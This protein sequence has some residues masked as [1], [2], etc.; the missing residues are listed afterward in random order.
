MRS[1]LR[2]NNM[3]GQGSARRT[4]VVY[5]LGGMGKTQLAV[6]YATWHQH[7]YSA[8]FW[9]NARDETT[10]KQ[11]FATVA[12][13]ILRE[14]PSVVYVAN[15]IQSRDLDESV[16]AVKRWLDQ[17][18]NNHWLIVYNNYNNSALRR[19]C[20]SQTTKELDMREADGDT[21]AVSRA[22][23]IR[24]LEQHLPHARDG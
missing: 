24:D 6:A 3:L 5:G 2:Y 19:N 13:R 22:Y 17:P 8:M 10:L 20:G 4:A 18:K 12:E 23:D 11:G 15:A 14:H 7:D 9:L 1:S 21:N 16:G